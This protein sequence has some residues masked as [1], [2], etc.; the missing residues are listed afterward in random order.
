MHGRKLLVFFFLPDFTYIMGNLISFFPISEND[1]LKALENRVAEL[2]KVFRAD[3]PD[4]K[5]PG[6]VFTVSGPGDDIHFV[7]PTCEF[8]A[9]QLWANLCLNNE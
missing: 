4:P 6:M 8:T 9:R 3:D 1:R 7:T 5:R 2:E